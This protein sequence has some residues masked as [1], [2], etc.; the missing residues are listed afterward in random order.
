MSGGSL[1]AYARARGGRPRQ[2]NPILAAAAVPAR[3]SR[4]RSITASCPRPLG[5]PSAL[6]EDAA[7]AEGRTVVAPPLM[8]TIVFG[9][10]VSKTRVFDPHS[11]RGSGSFPVS[12]IRSFLRPA[13]KHFENLSDALDN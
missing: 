2:A 3:K 1:D 8:R 10:G 13:Q 4:R 6:V 5:S 9:V 7:A 11:E 12:Q